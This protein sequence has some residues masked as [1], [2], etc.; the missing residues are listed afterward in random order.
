MISQPNDTEID[1]IRLY[2]SRTDQ[3]KWELTQ[4]WTIYSE[5]RQQLSDHLLTHIFAFHYSK[6]PWTLM[7]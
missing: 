1:K 6:L 2:I 7:N 3:E 5:E 4:T